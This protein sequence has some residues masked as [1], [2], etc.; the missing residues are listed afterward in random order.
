[1]PLLHSKSDK[2]LKKNI[3]VEMESHPGKANKAQN[4]AIA[5]SIQ[6]R[7]KGKKMNKGG[8][9]NTVASTQE[10][11]QHVPGD[12]ADNHAA[13]MGAEASKLP[14][15]RTSSNL[16][17][18]NSSQARTRMPMQTAPSDLARNRKKNFSNEGEA[19][20][21]YDG[22]AVDKPKTVGQM[23]GYPGADPDPQP[24][25]NPGDRKPA[26]MARGGD[27]QEH[28]EGIADAIMAKRRRSKMMAEGGMISED[29][30]SLETPA[31]LSPYDDDNMI[32]GK[33]ELYD[34]HQLSSQPEDSNLM[35][36]DREAETENQNDR[37]SRIMARRRKS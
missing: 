14:V 8:F 16:R 35:G 31:S 20:A 28:Y 25:S 36:D 15:G 17:G 5:F 23:I 21:M 34:V 12:L 24:S 7:A 19:M 2:A 11:T 4:L 3:K 1:M 18:D 27:V 9:V 30:D 10:D 33:K 37:V 22:G 6:R 29:D 26:G 32:A 13:R